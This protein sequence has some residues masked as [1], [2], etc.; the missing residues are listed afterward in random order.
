MI[1]VYLPWAPAC[2][3]MVC[4]LECKLNGQDNGYHAIDL[5]IFNWKFLNP[6]QTSS[7]NIEIIMD[8]SLTLRMYK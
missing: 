1:Y 3:F 5:E 7:I 8:V 4:D 6:Y 2:V